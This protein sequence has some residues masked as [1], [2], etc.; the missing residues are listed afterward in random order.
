MLASALLRML[1]KTRLAHRMCSRTLSQVL[2]VRR[3]TFCAALRSA[4]G[5]G[6]QG[7]IASSS[8]P[9]GPAA[10]PLWC[11]CARGRRNAHGSRHGDARSAAYQVALT[12]R[13]RGRAAAGAA[14]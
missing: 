14:R 2:I 11:A 4:Y 9:V 12:F 6:V 13:A 3:T 7:N 8:A 5:S 10:P 1:S